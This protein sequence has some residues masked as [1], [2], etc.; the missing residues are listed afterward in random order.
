MFGNGVSRVFLA[1]NKDKSR[2]V[3]M[4]QLLVAFFL[5]L[6]FHKHTKLAK[7]AASTHSLWLLAKGRG[8]TGTAKNGWRLLLSAVALVYA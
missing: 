8:Q 2:L 3:I 6:R 1:F 7:A 4:L 5:I